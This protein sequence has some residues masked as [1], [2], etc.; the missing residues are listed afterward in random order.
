MIK[1]WYD[2]DEVREFH[3]LVEESLNQILQEEGLDSEYGVKHHPVV[4]GST[5]IPDFSIYKKRSQRTVFILEVKRTER[6]VDSQ[7]HWNQTSGYIRDLT[8]DWEPGN[9]YF[10]VTNIEKSIIFAIREGSDADCVLAGNPILA[11]KFTPDTRDAT[12]VLEKFRTQIKK[13]VIAAISNTTP[14]WADSWR[15]IIN[16]FAVNLRSSINELSKTH[17]DE[18][19][20]EI[21]TYELLRV[22]LYHFISSYYGYTRSD[23][24]QFFRVS[25]LNTDPV[26]AF[27]ELRN[28]YT[29]AL[30]LDFKQIF[31]DS[32]TEEARITIE[33]F[34]KITTYFN[35][36]IT[37]LQSYLTDAVKQNYSPTYFFNLLT[38][39]LY[40]HE[41][42]HKE[43]KVMS[44]SELAG[45]LAELCI[46]ENTSRVLDPGC[47]DGAL[48]E[49]AYDKLREI[50]SQSTP[51]LSHQDILDCMS[52]IEIDPFLTQL[53]AF[54]LLMKSPN[55]VNDD[56]E[57]DITTG[58]VFKDERKSKYDV[59]L[60]NPP[61]LRN[62][63]N[64]GPLVGSSVGEMTDAIKA[65]GEEPF[66]SQASQPNLYFYFVNYANH[67]LSDRGKMG[68]ILMSKFMNNKDG[69]YLKTFLK[70]KVEAIITYPKSYF[71]GFNVTT[72]IVVLSKKSNCA[73]VK[74][75]NLRTETLLSSPSVIKDIL[76][77]EDT[78]IAPD[79]SLKIVSRTSLDP[80]ANWRTYL[81]D[82]EDKYQRIEELPGFT[83]LSNLFDVIKRGG[84]ANSGAADLVFPSVRSKLEI[85]REIP[86]DLLCFGIN[87][88]IGYK[89]FS[90]TEED[91]AMQQA[92]NFP[93]PYDDATNSG[94]SKTMSNEFLEKLYL[95]ASQKYP[96]W[97][98]I[99]NETYSSKIAAQIIIPRADRTKHAVYLNATGKKVI[100]STNFFAL[101]NFK[102]D[103]HVITEDKQIKFVCA[104][105]L[106]SFGQVQFELVANDQEGMRK[107]EGFML[108][109]LSVIDPLKVK[110]V[111]VVAVLDAFDELN[112]KASAF[113][114]LEG[115]DSPRKMLDEAISDALIEMGMADFQNKEM[116]AKFVQLFLADLVEDRQA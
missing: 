111:K 84:A 83:K 11:G 65:A 31:S 19:G 92:I 46:D 107:I 112:D 101:S 3:P 57:A 71:V 44:D 40:A 41:E 88:N 100:V 1:L 114:G 91:L 68:V 30:E 86:T 74:F 32:P 103:T 12:E 102:N 79:Y 5:K 38:E 78:I 95:L 27:S 9:K 16:S 70:D 29:K 87:H 37:I 20:K 77:N 34:K 14:V 60:M 7:R 104:F 56:T 25:R 55:E 8:H 45:L 4:A 61:F 105:L 10:A 90:L 52:G 62:E 82:P 47:G 85:A 42:L 13:T 36:F 26:N 80:E 48:L 110:A 96:N 75:L 89:H 67:F 49:A 23:N 50:K 53:A 73:E 58:D 28:S 98:K 43:G 22:F 17:G 15:P 69:V 35:S 108:D 64:I 76:N 115:T 24:V 99:L 51:T 6:D 39:N 97:K 59:V 33:Q 54:R 2:S 93:A 72:S 113:S 81:L 21:G 106:S 109:K 63:E 94:Y 66:V 18:L 116:L